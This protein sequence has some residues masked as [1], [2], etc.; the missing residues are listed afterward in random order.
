VA[1]LNE[2]DNVVSTLVRPIRRWRLFKALEKALSESPN[3]N[4]KDSDFIS[5]KEIQHQA[6]ANMAFRHPLRILVICPV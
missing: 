1:D 3:V 5:P 4:M 2:A 6:L